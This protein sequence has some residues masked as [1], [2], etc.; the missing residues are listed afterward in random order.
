MIVFLFTIFNFHF[1][2]LFYFYQLLG[3][4]FNLFLDLETV[5]SDQTL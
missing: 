1:Y 5:K 3:Y 2:A 4:L